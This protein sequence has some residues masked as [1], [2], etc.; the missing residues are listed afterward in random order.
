MKHRL[1]DLLVCPI[2]KAWPLKLEIS[3]ESKE[4]EDISLPLENPSTGVICGFFCN[5]KQYMLVTINKAG[6]EEVKSKDSIKKHVTLEDCKECFQID[7]QAGKIYCKDNQKHEYEIK[8]SIPVMLSPE[9]IEEIYGK[10]KNN[11]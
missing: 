10:R 4:K 9:K 3:K 6:E 11:N 8:E 7:I 5:Y 2:D 1:M